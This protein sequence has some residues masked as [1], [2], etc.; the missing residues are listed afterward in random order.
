MVRSVRGASIW[1][2]LNLATEVF[3][4][5][6][7]LHQAL[8]KHLQSKAASIDYGQKGGGKADPYGKAKAIW[9]GFGEIDW[10]KFTN[11]FINQQLTDMG[12]GLVGMGA[13]HALK[14]SGAA[15]GSGGVAS[16]PAGLADKYIDG[17]VER[18]EITK[19]EGKVMKENAE[20]PIPKVSY[21]DG[22]WT[23]DISQWGLSFK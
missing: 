14:F 11:V 5:I 21:E 3:D 23:V 19:A 17:M 20:L 1:V 13:S 18:G 8:P 10:N 12:I 2:G 15:T 16:K 9:D 6:D 22:K 4:F 7:A